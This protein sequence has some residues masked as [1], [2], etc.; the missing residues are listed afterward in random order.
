MNV[1]VLLSGGLDSTT[2]LAS[3]LAQGHKVRAIEFSYGS[4]HEVAEAEASEKIAKFYKVPRET[5]EIPKG[6]FYGGDSSLLGQSEI[7]K[8]VYQD[9]QEDGPS[10]TVVPFRNAIMISNAVAIANSLDYDAVAIAVHASDHAHWS[11]PDCSPEFIGAMT[12][13]VYSG[14]YGEV[15]LM[16]PFL[17]NTKADLVTLAAK[18][19]VPVELTWSCYQGANYACGVCPTCRERIAAF[20]TAGFIDPVEYEVEIFWDDCKP[21]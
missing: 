1:I 18:L 14:T 8:E 3:L 15:R 16:A 12:A 19:G 20:K 9:V 17:W 13:A 5:Y 7:P 11:Y 2:L 10:S 4:L 6:L 21:W